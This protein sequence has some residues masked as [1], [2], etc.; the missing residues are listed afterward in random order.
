MS[1]PVGYWLKLVD[2]LL[3]S[4]LDDELA[5]A[6]LT[7]RAWQVLNVVRDGPVHEAGVVA[8]LEPF[9][10]RAGAAELAELV[11]GGLVE[12]TA[13]GY[14][15][16][17]RGVSVHDDVSNRVTEFRTRV[18]DGISAE[19]YGTTLATLERMARNLGWS[20]GV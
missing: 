9:G 6:D 7:R 15:L 1:R 19:E 8:A 16:S 2:G 17:A 4:G 20:P 5:H 18:A 11:A 13:G 14:V 10:V 3:E 12:Q